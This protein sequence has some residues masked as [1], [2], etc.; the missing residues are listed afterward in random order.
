MKWSFLTKGKVTGGWSKSSFFWTGSSLKT[1]KQKVVLS[2][3]FAG[4]RKRRKQVLRGSVLG[5]KNDWHHKKGFWKQ[6]NSCSCIKL[7]YTHILSTVQS[8]YHH[9][10]G[11][12]L[13]RLRR[14]REENCSKDGT[15]LSGKIRN[16]SALQ[17]GEK[18]VKIHLK[19]EKSRSQ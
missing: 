6:K 17:L 13:R 4:W 12:T 2:G 8:Y 18:I 15:V 9:T 16:I 1:G 7:W 11:R 5:L 3:R 19:F 14:Y 10:S